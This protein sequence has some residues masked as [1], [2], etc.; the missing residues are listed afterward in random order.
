MQL[1]SA[2]RS[3]IRDSSAGAWHDARRPGYTLLELA[4]GLGIGAFVLAALSS[5][6]FF[7]MNFFRTINAETLMPVTAR[8]L[9]DHLYFSLDDAD[10]KPMGLGLSAYTREQ[11]A[12][13]E[14]GEPDAAGG[15]PPKSLSRIHQPVE[16]EFVTGWEALATN[17]Q[18]VA[19]LR[20]LEYRAVGALPGGVTNRVEF[21]FY[22]TPAGAA[23]EPAVV[24]AYD[25]DGAPAFQE[26][27][28]GK[29]AV[30]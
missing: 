28:E 14:L 15:R 25:R 11:V 29:G 2:C 13:F 23:T 3:R 4:I 12:A 30:L 17:A 6:A 7:V 27:G 8:E 24:N 19:V 9:R 5:Y 26:P 20:K 18:T 22:V 10:G 16:S 1:M 21:P